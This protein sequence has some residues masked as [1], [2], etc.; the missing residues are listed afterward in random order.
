MSKILDIQKLGT[1]DKVHV[2]ALL[3]AFLQSNKPKK[4]FASSVKIKAARVSSINL[5]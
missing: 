3:D 4:V 5:Y 1:E 2:C